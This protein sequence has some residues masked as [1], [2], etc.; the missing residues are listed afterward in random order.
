[1]K[2]VLMILDDLNKAKLDPKVGKYTGGEPDE[3]VY[4]NS[5][6]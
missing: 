2:S 1:M 6:L 4:L 5:L 3:D